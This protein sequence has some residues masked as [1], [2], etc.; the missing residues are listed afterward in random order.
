MTL[1][2]ESQRRGPADLLLALEALV[3]LVFFRICLAIVPVRK[4]IRAITP[5]G[6]VASAEERGTASG[7]DLEVARR[8][9]WAVSAAARHSFVEFVCFPQTLAGYVLL[10]W[11]RVPSTMVY[12]VARS[13]EGELL[14]HTWLEVGEKIVTGGDVSG[15]FTPV[16]QWK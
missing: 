15:E 11:R 13:P 2:K 3:L 9:E 16:E 6:A 8:V 7:S 12:G 14:A 4:I 10:R 5:G 1:L